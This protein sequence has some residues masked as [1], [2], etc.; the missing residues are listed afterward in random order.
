[1]TAGMQG[2]AGVKSFVP[3]LMDGGTGDDKPSLELN[4]LPFEGSVLVGKKGL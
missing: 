2:V 3:G 1:V 4:G